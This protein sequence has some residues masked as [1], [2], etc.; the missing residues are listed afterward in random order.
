L[1]FELLQSIPGLQ[2]SNDFSSADVVLHMAYDAKPVKIRAVN[3]N[4]IIGL[5]DPRPGHDRVIAEAD[6]FMANGVE[7]V[8]Y[9][10]SKNPE[11]FIYPIY[12]PVS[13]TTPTKEDEVFRVG[14]HG[15]RMHLEL[16]EEIVCPALEKLASLM[17]VE[18][19]CFY[20]IENL[21]MWKWRPRNTQLK[22]NQVQWE[23]DKY[24]KVLGN[25][26]VGIVPNLIPFRPEE[27]RFDKDLVFRKMASDS[28]YRFRFKF[29]SNNGRILVFAQLG[30]PVISD[31]F[32]SAAETI[33]H[34]YS[35]LMAGMDTESWFEHLNLLAGNPRLRKKMGENLLKEF[36]TVYSSEIKNQELLAFLNSILAK[37][38]KVRSE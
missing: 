34:G 14:Y 22:L 25:C 7:M 37:R 4:A 21:G 29:T 10:V 13:R 2:F 11:Y 30:I 12:K 36:E 31:L 32:P 20:N 9:F 24:E 26:D 5:I 27:S 1:N 15:N 38:E 8:N 6:F 19:I 33:R 35:G 18:L 3:P 28:D 17:P 23:D 16:M